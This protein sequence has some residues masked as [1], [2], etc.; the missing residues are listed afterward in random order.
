MRRSGPF[1]TEFGNGPNAREGVKMKA[2]PLLRYL[3]AMGLLVALAGFM[4]G[5]ATPAGAQAQCPGEEEEEQEEIFLT[6]TDCE[7]FSVFLAVVKAGTG[8]GD[9]TAANGGIDCGLVCV[10]PY[11]PGTQVTLDAILGP[12]SSF[13]G[14]TVSEGALNLVGCDGTGPCTF[15]LQRSVIVTAVFNALGTVAQ[16]AVTRVC[17]I[18]QHGGIVTGPWHHGVRHL[19][20]HTHMNCHP[21]IN[22]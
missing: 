21:P 20:K 7:D 16:A 4:L 15:V 12:N 13:G 2:R 14:W 6:L 18:H 8:T 3:S 1:V 17:H 11:L 22:V 19:H 9:V 5:P 10:R